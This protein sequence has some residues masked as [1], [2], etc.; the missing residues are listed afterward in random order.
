[1]RIETDRLVLRLPTL[2]DV[3][4]VGPL[5]TDPEVV[6]FLGGEVAPPEIHGE[7]LEKWLERWD[8]Y[9]MGP[10]MVE[11]D[12]EFVGRTG[13]L[14]WD[15][16]SWTHRGPKPPEEFMQPEIGWAFVRAAW[17]NG[18]A[19]EAARAVLEWARAERGIGNLIS[20]IHPDN[21]RSQHV[22]ERLGATPAETVT[23]ADNGIQS[24]VWR[25]PE[26]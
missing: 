18:Y 21:I 4:V 10:F 16:R 13:I 20:M 9:G 14:V 3:A 8:E 5:L 15:V 24:V 22:A 11:R 2:D 25:Y 1:M 19:T 6:H 12:G 26:V 23:Q 17:G 7:I